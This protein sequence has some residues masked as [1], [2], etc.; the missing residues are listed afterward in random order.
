MTSKPF[1]PYEMKTSI[2]H[3]LSYE[4]KK[5]EGYL[6][7]A[8]FKGRRY[9]SNLTQMIFLVEELLDAMIYPS[10]VTSLRSF[11]TRTTRR[12]AQENEEKPIASFR[13]SVLFRQNASWQGNIQWM[14]DKKVIPFRSVL[15]LIQLIDTG[16]AAFDTRDDKTSKNKN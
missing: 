2:I 5:L 1:V 8:F 6:E 12:T 16:L 10:R 7:S 3:V 11:T 15:E 9:F 14:E 4:D 13:L